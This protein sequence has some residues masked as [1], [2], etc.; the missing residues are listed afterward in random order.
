MGIF[1]SSEERARRKNEKKEVRQKTQNLLYTTADLTMAYTIIDVIQ[2]ESL[3]LLKQKAVKMGADAIVGVGFYG[4]DSQCYGTAVQLT[5]EEED[6]EEQPTPD[7]V[8]G[9]ES[10]ENEV[11]ETPPEVAPPGA[12]VSE[13]ETET[14][15][16]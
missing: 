9:I 7:E 6:L 12:E 11:R 8:E 14:G 4:Y 1:L 13:P 15:T 16:L 5:V 10:Q 2:A 3:L